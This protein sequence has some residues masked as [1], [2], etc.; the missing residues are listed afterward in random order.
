LLALCFREIGMSF[1][2]PEQDVSIQQ[3]FHG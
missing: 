1:Q 2:I 3:Q